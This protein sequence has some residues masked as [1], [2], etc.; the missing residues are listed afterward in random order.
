MRL[1]CS[2]SEA[3]TYCSKECQKMHW[4]MHK[5]SCDA[6]GRTPKSATMSNEAMLAAVT[7]YL[8]ATQNLQRG[9]AGSI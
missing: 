5:L 6:G 1:K 7:A 8:T 3:P 9:R 2:C 4:K